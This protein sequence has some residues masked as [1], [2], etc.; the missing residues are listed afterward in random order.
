MLSS[1]TQ[2]W[3]PICGGIL[4]SLGLVAVVMISEWTWPWSWSSDPPRDE[5]YDRLKI[6][7]QPLTPH[8]VAE[9]I[10]AMMV[11]AKGWGEGGDIAVLAR[12]TFL[13]AC[14]TALTKVYKN[15]DAAIE[16]YIEALQTMLNGLEGLV[17]LRCYLE[18]VNTMFTLGAP[19]ALGFIKGMAQMAKAKKI[20]ALIE[21]IQKLD[22]IKDKAEKIKKMQELQEALDQIRKQVPLSQGSSSIPPVTTGDAT[23]L[24][25]AFRGLFT[26]P[27]STLRGCSP[28]VLMLGLSGVLGFF[29]I[30]AYLLFGRMLGGQPNTTTGIDQDSGPAVVAEV[31]LPTLEPTDT[32]EPTATPSPI[33]IVLRH[34]NFTEEQRAQIF[35]AYLLDPEGDWIYSQ[36][37]VI[38]QAFEDLADVADATD[39]RGHLGQR[40]SMSQS[41][42]DS[43][44]NQSDF[45]CDSEIPSGFVVCPDGAGPIPAGDVYMFVMKL[46]GDLPVADPDHFY[47]YAAVVDADGNPDNNFQYQYPYDW[48]YFQNTDRWY[49]LDWDPN[50]G[51]WYFSVTDVVKQL[52]FAPSDARAVVMGDTVIFFVPGDEITADQ[53]SYRLTAF[54]HDGNYSPDASIGDVTGADPTEPLAPV[55]M[56]PI[57]ID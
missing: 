8:E 41:A 49:S 40:L 4:F 53:I 48:D 5:M 11:K 57:V 17:W 6:F 37:N 1:G 2:I 36:S 28:V 55:N 13:N 51:S 46:A 14:K 27:V 45:P 23:Q 52:W 19:G 18:L 50:T 25:A 3:I 39:I 42:V 22:S 16:E 43:S 10:K 30:M 54:A 12:K 29:V 38:I 47:T 34:G 24:A 56:A 7:L 31:N 21:Q 9:A 20:L 35:L 15:K 32:P 26:S 44:F 33:D